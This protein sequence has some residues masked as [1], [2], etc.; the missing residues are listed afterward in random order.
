MKAEIQ[1]FAKA[2]F[3][4]VSYGKTWKIMEKHGFLWFPK[5]PL[6]QKTET[7]P[8][9]SITRW[10]RPPG[11]TREHCGV[12]CKTLQNR[13]AGLRALFIE[14]GSIIREKNRLKTLPRL[15]GCGIRNEGA[16]LEALAPPP[17]AH[18]RTSGGSQKR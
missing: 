17:G 6:Q 13:P 12:P 9:K 8:L 2:W 10:R 1:E 7:D 16:P 4:M 11:R 3:P 18:T 5:G 15:R 14:R